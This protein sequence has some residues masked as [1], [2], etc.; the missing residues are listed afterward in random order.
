VPE[1]TRIWPGRQAKVTLCEPFS[2][3]AR[4]RAPASNGADGEQRVAN[5]RPIQPR[6]ALGATSQT[7]GLRE[8]RERFAAARAAP[9]D[10]RWIGGL[11]GERLGAPLVVLSRGRHRDR[12]P[13][14][15]ALQV[16]DHRFA[17]AKLIG[18]AHLRGRFVLSHVVRPRRWAR[19]CARGATRC[20]PPR[21]VTMADAGA[22][23][24]LRGASFRA[25]A[26]TDRSFERASMRQRTPL[27][28][29]GLELPI[30]SSTIELIH[31]SNVA[32][33]TKNA[34]PS[35]GKFWKTGASPD[36][37]AR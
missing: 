30:N 17:R 22:F 5:R 6:E 1:L 32:P 23:A 25:A 35:S 20:P 26:T 37:S 7:P 27:A 36:A 31:A 18:D 3:Q 34:A 14:V 33:R 2:L 15:V 8:H 4:L 16:I 10:F 19:Q 11:F 29:P 28:E 13:D 24:T 21:R 12:D 9:T